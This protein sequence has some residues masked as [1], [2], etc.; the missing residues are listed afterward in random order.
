[1]EH[2]L[3]PSLLRSYAHHGSYFSPNGSTFGVQGPAR[4]QLPKQ[5][6]METFKMESWLFQDQILMVETNAP[7]NVDHNLLIP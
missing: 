4:A 7:S 6:A 5:R 2:R 1:M 3:N